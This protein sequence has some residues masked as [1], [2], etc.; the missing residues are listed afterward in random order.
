MYLLNGVNGD[1]IHA[2]DSSTSIECGTVHG[3]HLFPAATTSGLAGVT[4]MASRSVFV[5]D[6]P[7][8]PSQQ[9]T[10]VSELS[11]SVRIP[12]ATN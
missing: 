7:L 12:H 9:P 11:H 1:L 6:L 10:T 8:Q 3:I 5:I 2:G 4:S